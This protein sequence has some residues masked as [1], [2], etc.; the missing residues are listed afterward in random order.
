MWIVADL[1]VDW[2]AGC[3][4]MCFVEFR[5]HSDSIDIFR[6]AIINTGE[7]GHNYSESSDV[8]ISFHEIL[9]RKSSVIL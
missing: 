5:N 9:P 7:N 3:L 2:L 6:F 8:N 1:L 4:L